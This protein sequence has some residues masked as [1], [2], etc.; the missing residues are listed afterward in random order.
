M[1]ILAG[2]DT[3]KALATLAL[4]VAGVLSIWAMLLPPQGEIDQSVLLAV[5]QFLVFSAT[6]LGVE[7]AVNRIRDIVNGKKAD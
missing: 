6:L 3:K 5:A 4:V 1:G 2:V 7:L